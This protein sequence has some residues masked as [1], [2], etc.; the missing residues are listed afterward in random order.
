MPTSRLAILV[1]GTAKFALITL[2]LDPSRDG[3]PADTLVEEIRQTIQS[4]AL[5]DNWL[6]EKVAILDENGST[7]SSS[8]TV[9]VKQAATA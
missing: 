2:V 5:S 6:I 4:S 3:L 7:T 1:W 8:P 9:K